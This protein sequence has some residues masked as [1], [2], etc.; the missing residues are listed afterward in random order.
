[1]RHHPV[2][3]LAWLS[4]REDTANIPRLKNLV[5]TSH[6][7]HSV[8]HPTTSRCYGYMLDDRN[9]AMGF[10]G[11]WRE[12]AME[13]RSSTRRSSFFRFDSDLDATINVQP[14]IEP[15]IKDAIESNA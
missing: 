6:F 4:I 10:K 3:K 7:F 1:V 15:A 5:P 2:L 14:P 9:V 8:G 12:V 11:L 13:Q